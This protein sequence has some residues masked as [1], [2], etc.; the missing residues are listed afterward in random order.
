LIIDEFSFLAEGVNGEF[1]KRQDSIYF[2]IVAENIL[3]KIDDYEISGF[4]KIGLILNENGEI[5]FR[6]IR[7]F[8]EGLKIK[9]KGRVKIEKD[10]DYTFTLLPTGKLTHMQK[11][12]EIP[13]IFDGNG[14]GE[15]K[16]FDDE[17][18]KFNANLSII[19]KQGKIGGLNVD[20]M[21]SLVNIKDDIINFD[22]R[23]DDIKIKGELNKE[24]LKVDINNIMFLEF[25]K[26][27]DIEFPFDAKCNTSLTLNNDSDRL[28]GIAYC[29]SKPL[30]NEDIISFSGN[31]NYAYNSNSQNLKVEANKITSEEDIFNILTRI[32]FKNDYYQQLSVSGDVIRFEKYLPVVKFFTELDFSPWEPDGDGNFFL[33]MKGNFEQPELTTDI[34][35]ED[36]L[37]KDIYIGK[38]SADVEY[39]DGLTIGNYI[40]SGKNYKGEGSFSAESLKNTTKISVVAEKADIEGVSKIFN[41][42]YPIRGSGKGKLQVN[43]E[44]GED[45]YIRGNISGGEFFYVNEKFTDYSAYLETNNYNENGYI[46][47]ENID[48]TYNK[49]KVKGDIFLSFEKEIF[50]EFN[51][52]VNGKQVDLSSY[53]KN[54]NGEFDFSLNGK[55][56]FNS[57]K[58]IFKAK[59][60]NFKTFYSEKTMKLNANG[61]IIP[62]EEEIK[63][64]SEIVSEDKKLNSNIK[65]KINWGNKSLNL[66]II[67]NTK[68]IDSFIPWEH[69]KGA[70]KLNSNIT[71]KWDNLFYS[72]TIQSQG[73]TLAIPGYSQSIDDYKLTLNI[74]NDTLRIAEL[75]GTLGGGD[76][77]GSGY[78]TLSKGELIDMNIDV[79]GKDLTLFPMEKL[80]GVASGNINISMDYPKFIINGNV[81]VQQME[82]QREF[83]E[84]VSF[85]SKT[86]ISPEQT[87]FLKK[88]DFNINFSADENS[89]VKNSLFEGE[90]KYDLTIKGNYLTPYIL[91]Q[92]NV[93]KGNLKFSDRE[94]NIEKGSLT[95]DNPYYI[96][97]RLNI[98]SEGYIKDYRVNF[99]ISGYLDH[100][101]PEFSSAPPL[102]KQEILTLI[103]MGET[104]KRSYSA[105]VAELK[106][107]SSLLATSITE[108]L[109]EKTLKKLDI[110]TIRIYPFMKG[111]SSEPSPRISIGKKINKDLFVIYSFDIG[112][113]QRKDMLFAIYSL[114]K[115]IS[116]VA[117][118]DESNEYNFELRI[119][120]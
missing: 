118:R 84:G 24:T 91:G 13:Y 117:F 28:N 30:Q 64:N 74:N 96:N 81:D 35:F 14:H 2:K 58:L 6:N 21:A 56:V 114:T 45:Y 25:F 98:R 47:L 94:F 89:W 103:A 88:F 106:G 111:S 104:Y 119:I 3:I 40:F 55:G 95:F 12:F 10:I 4:G 67:L 99:D 50:K 57:D 42:L 120:R 59:S 11:V 34:I 9:G 100:P 87:K 8:P 101:I 46:K 73:K 82:W 16:I 65:G 53:Y 76:I 15:I 44:N 17:N 1:L 71:G 27:Y 102:P 60:P 38:A 37:L 115:N 61:F 62:F 23:A 49:G 108:F 43:I 86:E 48:A 83:E 78:L 105:E 26:I 92:V 7:L 51:F 63:L 113:N 31:L 116:M 107:S 79:I 69:N 110:D 54:I 33:E 22:V 72:G 32:N 18:N 29:K 66:N 52:D 93:L 39:A 90:I 68:K 5:L 109:K 20:R 36:F 41:I 19:G 77:T 85:S 75:E 80:R 97:P 70:I 112:R